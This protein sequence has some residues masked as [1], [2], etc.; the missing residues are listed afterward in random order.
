MAHYEPPHQDLRCLQIQLFSS[1]VVKELNMEKNT[2]TG[3]K[4]FSARLCYYNTVKILKFWTPQTMAITVLEIE[5]FDVTL[6]YCIQKM[7][8]EWQTA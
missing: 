8:M 1:L 4:V 6:L 3:D 2:S 7:L 5:K